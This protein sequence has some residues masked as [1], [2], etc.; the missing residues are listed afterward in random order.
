M[1]S[2]SSPR[3]RG[4]RAAFP[5]SRIPCRFIP[6]YAGNA[7]Q[8]ICCMWHLMVHPRVCG[9]R[10]SAVIESMMTV[11]SSPR[12][13][14]T[15]AQ[16][17]DSDPRMRFI[18]A[19]AGNAISSTGISVRASVHP[20]VCGE[21][22]ATDLSG[23]FKGGSSPRMRGTPSKFQGFHAPIRFIPAYAGNARKAP[24]P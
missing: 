23:A 24:A 5:P 11:G 3:M 1:D 10:S 22:I 12:M 9:E 17:H 4:T 15:R 20:R 19:Y 6:A 14:G 7:P 13:R 8:S 18:P 2:G 21:R 16:R